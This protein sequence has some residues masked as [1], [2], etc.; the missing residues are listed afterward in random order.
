MRFNHEKLKVYQRTLALNVKIA[1]WVDKWDNK[2]AICDHLPRAAESMLENIATAS[3]SHSRMKLK[4]LDYALGSAL[5]CAA[6]LDLAR[7]KRLLDPSPVNAEKESLSQTF[8][9]LVGLRR[10]WSDDMVREEEERYGTDTDFQQPGRP[11]DRL[12][13]E[14]K[15]RQKIFFHH[16]RLDVYSTALDM[17]KA[18]SSSNT[19]IGLPA[20]A[21]RR[22]DMLL[23]GIVLNI[24]EGNG[25]FSAA[26]QR[27]FSWLSHEAVIK[28]AAKLDL[29]VIQGL[30]PS[31]Q[32][33][34]WKSLLSRLS[35]MTTAMAI[36]DIQ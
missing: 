32:V 29:Y 30:L 2:H 10:A 33:H 26:D 13:E 23:T 6:C 20:K 17:V 27:R 36:E 34:D 18:L 15:E 12:Q 4:R 11:Q 22:L 9:M 31:D 7:I 16:E 28:T 25:R 35:A 3:A 8:K 5:E 24:A 14:A 21:F 1:T 19:V